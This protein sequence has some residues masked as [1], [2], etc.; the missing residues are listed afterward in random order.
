MEN[1]LDVLA[2][3]NGLTA[4]APLAMLAVKIRRAE[5]EIG[6][7]DFNWRKFIGPNAEDAGNAYLR[8]ISATAP[9]GGCY[10]KTDVVIS[11]A[12]GTEWEARFDVKH[13]TEPDNDTDLRQHVRDFLFFQLHPEKIQWVRDMANSNRWVERDRAKEILANMTKRADENRA[14]YSPFLSALTGGKES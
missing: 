8:E 9:K 4:A 2:E 3:A 14:E 10:D 5:G 6:K 13:F 7:A 12:D 1:V 11:F